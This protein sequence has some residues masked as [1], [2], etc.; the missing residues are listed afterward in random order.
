LR[1]IPGVLVFTL[2]PQ[3][4]AVRVNQCQLTANSVLPVVLD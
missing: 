1:G 2:Q 4:D 3:Y